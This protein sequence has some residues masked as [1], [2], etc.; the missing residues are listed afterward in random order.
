MK[1]DLI[2]N[3]PMRLYP[4]L[5]HG[6]CEIRQISGACYVYTPILD[7]PWDPGVTPP[8]QPRYQPVQYCT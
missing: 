2:K 3:D 6:T 4:E 7:N 5:R 1:E 8:N